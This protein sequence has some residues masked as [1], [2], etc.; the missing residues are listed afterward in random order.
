[1]IFLI[2]FH[3]L[4]FQSPALVQQAPLQTSYSVQLQPASISLQGSSYQLQ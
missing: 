2:V 1:M 3:F 4:A